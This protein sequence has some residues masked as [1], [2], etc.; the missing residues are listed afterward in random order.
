MGPISHKFRALHDEHSALDNKLRGELARPAP[1]L[2][3]VG[4]LK[5]EK[6][7]VKDRIAALDRSRAPVQA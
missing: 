2:V 7:A 4:R 6:L 5:R 3:T 1:D